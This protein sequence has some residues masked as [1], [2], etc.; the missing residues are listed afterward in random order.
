MKDEKF[1]ELIKQ[2]KEVPIQKVLNYFDW[3]IDGN[4]CRCPSPL[5]EDSHP[6]AIVNPKY[7]KVFCPVC[8]TNE[9]TIATYRNLSQ[10]VNHETV[11]F[12]DACYRKRIGICRL[13]ERRRFQTRKEN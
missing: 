10:K 13:P 6:S 11:P 12:I 2:A 3:Q 5:H 1:N 8:R 9:D 4:V 7:N